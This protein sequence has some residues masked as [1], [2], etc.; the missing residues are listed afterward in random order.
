MHNYCSFSF[1]FQWLIEERRLDIG[2]AAME[3]VK[4]DKRKIQGSKTDTELLMG[5]YTGALSLN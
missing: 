1:S 5:G 4:G 3:A 2:Q